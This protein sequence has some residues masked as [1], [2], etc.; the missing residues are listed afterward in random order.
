MEINCTDKRKMNQ[1]A[2]TKDLGDFD[3]RDMDQND[4]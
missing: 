1:T 3:T 4:F 2:A